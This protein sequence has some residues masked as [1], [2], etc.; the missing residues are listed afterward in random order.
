MSKFI[1][2]GFSDEIDARLSVQMDELDKL[3]IHFIEMRGVDDKN[4]AQHSHEDVRAIKKRLDARGFKVSAVGSP[5]GKIKIADDF[6]PHLDE[7][8]HVLETAKILEAPSIR[9]FSFFMPVGEDPAK[10]R[11]EVLRRWRGFIAAAKGSGIKLLHENEK[12]IYG[13]NA[14][15]C[16]DLVES[17]GSDNLKLIFDPANFIQCGVESYPAAYQLLKDHVVYLHI[18][19]ALRENGTVRPAGY[20][21]GRIK[22]TLADLKARGFEGFLSLEPHLGRFKGFAELEPNSPANH[23]PDGGPKSFAFAAEALRKLLAEI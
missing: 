9:M 7:F 21:D 5:I 3:D 8:R 12:G 17:L 4:I 6:A 18:K 10:H 11:D 1:L 16:L 14:E 13:D 20:G 22:E 2:S 19:D 15:R 23:L